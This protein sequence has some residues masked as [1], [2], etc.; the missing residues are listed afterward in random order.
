M[1]CHSVKTPPA[2]GSNILQPVENPT[3]E[4]ER[5][6]REGGRGGERVAHRQGNTLLK[7]HLQKHSDDIRQYPDRY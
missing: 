4:R 6:E 7:K 1:S 5:R 2:E 3:R